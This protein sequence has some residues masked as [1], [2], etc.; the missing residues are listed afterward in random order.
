[1]SENQAPIPLQLLAIGDC[2]TGGT[3][4]HGT[5][6]NVPKQLKEKLQRQ[7]IDCELHN[8]GTTMSTCREGLQMSKD[9][10]Q[11]AD[12][13]LLNFGLVDA[14]KTSIPQIYI[15]YYPDN[16]LKKIAR[17]LLK[18]LK[19]RLRGPARKGW[20]KSGF[21]VEPDEYQSKMRSIIELQ[22]RLNPQLKVIL[23]GSA[24][25]DNE[26]RN[27]WL[28]S[29]DEYL[30]EIANGKYHYLD[31][32]ELIKQAIDSGA[33]RNDIYDDSV[34]LSAQGASLI[35]SAMQSIIVEEMKQPT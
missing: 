22:L 29:Y 34:H 35:A 7:G 27:A 26:E 32:A 28:A 9:H 6:F 3:R 23:W 24:P 4:E 19:K 14:W 12:Y 15:S 11:A 25:T 21:A 1:M 16:K 18:S 5:H 30:K 13:L 33:E 10:Q 2:N 20:V 17:K 8:Y 31:T